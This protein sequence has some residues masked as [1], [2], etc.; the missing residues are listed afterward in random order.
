[1]TGEFY[2]IVVEWWESKI[3]EKPGSKIKSNLVWAQFK[4]DNEN[5][6]SKIDYNVFKDIICAFIHEK[7]LI[8]PKTKT[9]AIEIENYDWKI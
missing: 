3:S 9:G 8:K 7:Y 2:C 1:M 6:A 5:V 4:K